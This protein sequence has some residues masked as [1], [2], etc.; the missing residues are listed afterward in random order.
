MRPK[1]YGLNEEQGNEVLLASVPDVPT[2]PVPAG[3]WWN[4]L[5]Q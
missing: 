1:A 3:W 5:I 2:R 4:A